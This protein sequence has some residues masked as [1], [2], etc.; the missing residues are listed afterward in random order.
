[1]IPDSKLLLKRQSDVKSEDTSKE[2]MWTTPDVIIF[3]TL[4]HG[5]ILDFVDLKKLFRFHIKPSPKNGSYV[6]MDGDSEVQNMHVIWN[7]YMYMYFVD[8]SI[9]YRKIHVFV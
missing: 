9:I 1:M 4:Y 2:E 3:F 7:G 6:T 8:L 5:F